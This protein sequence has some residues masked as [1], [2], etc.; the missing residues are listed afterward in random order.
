[1]SSSIQNLCRAVNENTSY[2]AFAPAFSSQQ[3]DLLGG[4]LLASDLAV[5]QVLIDQGAHDRTL[6][7]IESGALSV[8]LID[9][10]GRMQLAVLGPGSVVGEG[11]FFARMPRSANAVSTGAGRVWRLTPLR[12]TEM[13]NRQPALALELTMALGSV[14]A[15]RMMNRLKR[16]AVT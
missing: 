5:G 6:F 11:A 16:V 12:F 2:D 9:P 10:K 13:A 3:W 1:M 7:F 15:K 8:H 4:Y 14:L